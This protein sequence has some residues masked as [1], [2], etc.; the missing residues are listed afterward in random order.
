MSSQAEKTRKLD[1]WLV[2][3]HCKV[4]DRADGTLA[5]HKYIKQIYQDATVQPAT[6]GRSNAHLAHVAFTLR[7]ENPSP[8]ITFMSGKGEKMGV[9]CCADCLFYAVIVGLIDLSLLLRFWEKKNK[10]QGQ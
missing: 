8:W 10:E 7:E 6:R 1:A 2:W 9:N 5:N 3:E 4:I